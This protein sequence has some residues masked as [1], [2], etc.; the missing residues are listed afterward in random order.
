MP[1]QRIE[2]VDDERLDV[3]RNI[4]TRNWTEASG[5]FVVEGALL[6]ERLLASSYTCDSILVD[7]KYRERFETQFPHQH[8][9]CLPHREVQQL[10]GFEF[11][12]GILAA[13]RRRELASFEDDTFRDQGNEVVALIC[14]IEDPENLGGILRSCAGMGVSRVVVGPGCCDPF[15]RRALRVAM[16]TTFWISLFR[17]QDVEADLRR[18]RASSVDCR[19]YAAA[20]TDDST[21]LEQVKPSQKSILLFGNERTGLPNSVLEAVD[22]RVKITMADSISSLNVGVAAGIFLYHFTRQLG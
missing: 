10:V 2:S 15:S 6:A 18:L 19:S 1:I 4:R 20:L 3:F 21:P 12:R 13:G 22:E 8:I 5:R 14:G 9:F 17:S 16:G 7:E 11:H